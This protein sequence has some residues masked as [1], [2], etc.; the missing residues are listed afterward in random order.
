MDKPQPSLSRFRRSRLWYLLFLAPF[1]L[2]AAL[3]AILCLDHD[4]LHSAYDGKDST[5][6]I[7]YNDRHVLANYYREHGRLPD[8]VPALLRGTGDWA[9]NAHL[10][11]IRKSFQIRV[12]DDGVT[13]EI[14]SQSWNVGGIFRA[15]LPV[16]EAIEKVGP[17]IRDP[18]DDDK[19][20]KF[21]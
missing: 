17:W 19:C 13:V 18:L 14:I 21:W 6:A 12:R 20:W 8:D 2:V 9:R 10:D 11:A 4:P 5:V 16:G 15:D 7:I 3:A 1:A